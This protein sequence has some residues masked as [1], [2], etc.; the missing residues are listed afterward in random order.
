MQLLALVVL[1]KNQQQN[2]KL[3]TQNPN[4]SNETTYAHRDDT[5]K[6]NIHTQ[7]HTHTS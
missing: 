5:N 3:T 7:M 1:T 4:N 6:Q 2:F